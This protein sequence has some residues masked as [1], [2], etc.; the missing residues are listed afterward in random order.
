MRRFIHLANLT[1]HKSIGM[2][3]SPVDKGVDD[4]LPLVELLQRV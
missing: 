3:L 2:M 4:A 1:L